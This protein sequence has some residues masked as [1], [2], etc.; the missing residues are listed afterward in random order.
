M[1]S[2]AGPGGEKRRKA[3]GTPAG[4]RPP[5]DEREALRRLAEA[6]TDETSVDWAAEEQSHPRMS[7]RFERLRLIEKIAEVHRSG[8]SAPGP[9]EVLFEWGRLRVTEILGAGGFGTAYRAYDPLLQREVALKLLHDELSRRDLD[10]QRFLQEARRMARVRHANVLA[11][12]GADIQDGRVGFWADLLDGA[13][14]EERLSVEGVLGQGE[15]TI[16]G[17]ELC[18]ALAAVHAAGLVHGDIKASN[19][20]RETGGRIVLMDFGAGSEL[21]PATATGATVLGT[22]LALAPELFRGEAPSPAS[23]LYALAVL[24]YRLVSGRY[25]VTAESV[26]ELGARHRRGERVPLM[27]AR[28]D[29]T[30]AWIHVIDKGLSP[31]PGARYSTAGEME[32]ALASTMRPDEEHRTANAPPLPTAGAHADTHA[33]EARAAGTRG[34]FLPFLLAAFIVLLAGTVVLVKVHGRRGRAASPG[35]VGANAGATAA[36]GTAPG[37]APG[38]APLAAANAPALSA[39]VT[40]FRSQ[41]SAR[42]ALPAGA[43]VHPG[44][45][46]FMEVQGSEDLHAY[47]LN[48]DEAGEVHVLFPLASVDER[49]PLRGKAWHRLPGSSRGVPQDWQVTSGHG[50]ETFVVI[51]SRTP[52]AALE[53]Q[54]ARLPAA[55]SGHSVTPPRLDT[56]LLLGTRGVGGMVESRPSAQGDAAGILSQLVRSLTQSASDPGGLWIRQFVLYNLGR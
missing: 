37:I 6:I 46:L 34:R 52:L 25:P 47:V 56:G 33:A 1:E 41:G 40:L 19:V 17:I 24:L 13:T 21:V 31:D 55:S 45:A 20:M 22:P 5:R 11:I 26:E 4:T 32:A 23:D 29:L 35:D 16:V 14:L 10:R 28:P 48:E 2:K 8:F 49:N 53:E 54:I 39:D 27:D 12:H 3:E 36:P 7:S 51:A 18:R 42:E 15:A 43:L 44:D 30:P 50:K 38:M 9:D